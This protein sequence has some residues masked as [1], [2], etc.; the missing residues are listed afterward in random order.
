MSFNLNRAINDL[1]IS[2]NKVKFS[3]PAH[4][5][6]LT[7]DVSNSGVTMINMA[8]TGSNFVGFMSN[9]SGLYFKGNGSASF[10][11]ISGASSALSFSPNVALSFAGNNLNVRYNPDILSIDAQNQLNISN[12]AIYNAKLANSS[13]QI[14]NTVVSLG[15]ILS[16]IQASNISGRLT[17][18]NMPLDFTYLA[19]A[20]LNITS[21]LLNNTR[22]GQSL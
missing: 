10:D 16:S 19:T 17:S 22:I 7:I 9:S 1:E 13:I 11:Q 21:G 18:S 3:S 12:G 4:S 6:N 2:T 20:N 8:P 15:G 5:A 14:G